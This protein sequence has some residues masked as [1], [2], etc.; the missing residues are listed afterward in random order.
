MGFPL[1]SWG[2]IISRRKEFEE[3]LRPSFFCFVLYKSTDYMF[4][5]FILRNFNFLHNQSRDVVFFVLD[6]PEDWLKR[7]DIDYYRNIYGDSYN[8]ELNDE[9]VDSV[10]DYFGI[11]PN[12][13]PAIIT[14]PNLSSK[15][16]NV[17]SLKDVETHYELEHIFMTLFIDGN[18]R[19]QNHRKG[20]AGRLYQNAVT[21]RR[22]FPRISSQISY[23]EEGQSIVD[24]FEQI[25]ESI[26]QMRHEMRDGFNTIIS[27]L[28][29]IQDEIKPLKLA[30]ADK[31]CELEKLP[32]SNLRD[33][34]IEE[35]HNK[36]DEDL[37]KY[38]NQIVEELGADKFISLA[39]Y[40]FLECFEPDSLSMIR[41]CFITE[42][43]V[44]REKITEFDYSLCS[45]GF[46]KAMEIE[47]NIILIDTIRY[48][49]K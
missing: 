39:Q 45:V 4:R 21:L 17:F 18:E 44:S 9:E 24:K 38:S 14:F 27:K 20:Q 48:V 23:F 10:C 15:S 1:Q 2:D 41:S 7:D 31:F 25:N 36:V 32:H 3:L 6:K 40:S 19:T 16:C 37:I 43:L 47:L 22:R 42:K 34:E 13:L 33:N 49:K 35:L 5:E 11:H 26:N 30:L 8:P 28:E 12:K 46:W 29:T